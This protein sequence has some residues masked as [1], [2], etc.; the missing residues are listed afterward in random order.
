MPENSLER[1]VVFLE[2][3]VLELRRLVQELILRDQESGDFELVSEVV[4]AGLA[5]CCRLVLHW[6]ILQPLRD[7]SPWNIAEKV[8]KY[9]GT[10]GEAVFIGLPRREHVLPVIEAAGLSAPASF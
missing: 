4:L 10:V 1:R 5:S 3:E 8:V 9:R 2:R 7:P 6:R